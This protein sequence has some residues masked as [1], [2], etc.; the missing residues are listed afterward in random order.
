[1]ITE[2]R[3]RW[4]ELEYFRKKLKLFLNVEMIHFYL[5]FKQQRL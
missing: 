4:F 3:K 5:E 1:V 2:E